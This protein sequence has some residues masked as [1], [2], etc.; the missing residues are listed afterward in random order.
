MFPICYPDNIA[1]ILNKAQGSQQEVCEL[2]LDKQLVCGKR[3]SRLELRCLGL[4]LHHLPTDLY[5][6]L[7]ER[8]SR[9]FTGESWK[10]ESS[11]QEVL[12]HGI[13][14]LD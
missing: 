8:R 12:V 2:P 1:S 14:D 6:R 11:R 3:E 13:K 9:S 4:L 7:S 10:E 5:L